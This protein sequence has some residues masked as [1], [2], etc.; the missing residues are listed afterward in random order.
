MPEG[1][2]VVPNASIAGFEMTEAEAVPPPPPGGRAVYWITAMASAHGTKVKAARPSVAPAGTGM[3]KFGVDAVSVPGTIATAAPPA[4]AGA[5]SRT[6][7][8]SR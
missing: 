5:F 4:G 1:A 7:A 2:G 8:K 3:S 6:T